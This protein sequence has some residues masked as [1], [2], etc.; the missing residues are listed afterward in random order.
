MP[1]EARALCWARDDD[2]L[3]TR[4]H[5]APGGRREHV[6]ADGALILAPHGWSH[7]GGASAAAGHAAPLAS[8]RHGAFASLEAARVLGGLPGGGCYDA[9][10]L[11]APGDAPGLETRLS[12]SR[13]PS[14]A[15][16]LAQTLALSRPLFLSLSVSL[17]VRVCV[18]LCVSKANCH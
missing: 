11:S 15:R 10:A 17:C 2:E 18:C 7:D 13:S 1:H 6:G 16:S 12:P 9:P 3:L 8:P 14:P 4:G 5:G